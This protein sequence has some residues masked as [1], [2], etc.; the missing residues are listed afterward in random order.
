MHVRDDVQ[1]QAVERFAAFLSQPKAGSQPA[2][3]AA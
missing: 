1:T 2:G 3:G